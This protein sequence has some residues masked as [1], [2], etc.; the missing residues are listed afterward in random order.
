MSEAHTIQEYSVSK[1]WQK[2]FAI[3]DR[4][5]ASGSSF[6]HVMPSPEYQALGFWEK[7]KVSFNIW[8]F[9]FGAI[10]Y[11]CKTMWARGFVLLGCIWLVSAV[12]MLMEILFNTTFHPLAYWIPAAVICAQLA[13]YDYYRHKAK[14]EKFWS[15][16]STLAKLPVAVGF[17]AVAFVIVVGISLWSPV[18]IEQQE[19]TLLEDVSGVWRTDSKGE[20]IQLSLSRQLSTMKVDGTSVPISV[21]QID[22]DN[23]IVSLQISIHGERFI[24]T[25]RK[26]FDRDGNFTLLMT[27]HNGEEE[28]L[29]FVRNL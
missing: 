28:T 4:I 24:W 6:Y 11:F 23:H 16:T 29:G 25:V 19:E 1:S 5:N 10:Y 3:F 26:I 21:K 15:Q 12:L 7:Q 9:L 20:M 18:S 13:D 8:A 27:M 14:G 17:A 22:T 2:K